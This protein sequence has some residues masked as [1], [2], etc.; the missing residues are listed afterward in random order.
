VNTILISNF[1]TGETN[2]KN[3]IVWFK[4]LLTHKNVVVNAQKLYTG[5]RVR[6]FSVF[7][8]NDKVEVLVVMYGKLQLPNQ[9]ILETGDVF[10]V[11]K[12]YDMLVLEDVYVLSVEIYKDEN[13]KTSVNRPFW[14]I[15]STFTDL[16]MKVE[17][18]DVSTYG[19]SN[20]IRQ[21]S[22]AINNKLD[23]FSSS[24]EDFQILEEGAYFHDVGKIKVPVHIL[25]K[26]DKLT[27]EEY[28]LM[29][30]HTTYGREILSVF[31]YLSKHA[32]IAEQH[33]EKFDGSG[34]PLGLVKADILLESQIVAVADIFDALTTYRSYK[35]AFTKEQA[36]EIL[37][38]EPVNQEFVKALEAHL[39]DFPL[40]VQQA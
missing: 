35:S 37:K 40:G 32:L 39:K 29:K 31:P 17:T 18:Y 24:V 3:H 23:I 8:E 28:E 33:H 30:K 34:Y 38:R 26:T 1:E 27:P 11:D 10:I 19:H 20:R 6:Y 12:Y 9:T 13:L 21:Y 7:P 14:E 16:A 36:F 2:L 15:K 4:E 25:R 5:E 22:M